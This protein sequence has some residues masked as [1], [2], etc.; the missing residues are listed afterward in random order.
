MRWFTV[1]AILGIYAAVNHIKK[2][3][4]SETKRNVS[5]GKDD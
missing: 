5:C 4:V 1:I 3:L 2:E